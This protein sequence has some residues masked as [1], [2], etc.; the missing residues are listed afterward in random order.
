M[1]YPIRHFWYVALKKSTSEWPQKSPDNRILNDPELSNYYSIEVCKG[2]SF[3]THTF[4]IQS[5]NLF[6]YEMRQKRQLKI[7]S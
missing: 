4:L 3:G 1:K 6:F 7:M 5:H 2:L